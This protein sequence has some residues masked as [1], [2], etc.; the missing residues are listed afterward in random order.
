MKKLRMRCK[1]RGYIPAKSA[2]KNSFV[3]LQKFLPRTVETSTFSVD[4]HSNRVDITLKS[5]AENNSLEIPLHAYKFSG[6]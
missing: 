6:A 1:H 2:W 3:R 4:M 5:D